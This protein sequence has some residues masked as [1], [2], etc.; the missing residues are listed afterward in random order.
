M[1]IP[2]LDATQHHWVI[3]LTWV[4]FNTKYQK[5]WD[6]AAADALSQVTLKLDAET[7]VHPGQSHYGISRKSG[8]S[9][10]HEEPADRMLM[11]P[12]PKLTFSHHSCK[13]A[14]QAWCT[15]TTLEEQTLE[16]SETEEVPQSVNCLPLAQQQT[17][18]T[19]LG[20]M[21]RKLC[22][23]LQTFSRVSLLVQGWKVQCRGTRGVR[24][25]VGVLAAEVLVTPVR[26][27][28]YNWPW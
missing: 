17:V 14:E 3:S 13:W 6:N 19:P 21:N 28:G 25:G 10:P 2:N 12:P 27:L 26:L 4:T 23:I 8:H 11:S 5:G 7:E 24:E 22:A 9:Q 20:W 16:G 18:E 15:T 1:T